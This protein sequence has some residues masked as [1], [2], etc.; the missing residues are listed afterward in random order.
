MKQVLSFVLLLSSLSACALLSTPGTGGAAPSVTGSRP[1]DGEAGVSLNVGV[2]TDL[3]LP[4]SGVDPETL[5]QDAVTLTNTATGEQVAAT[6]GSSGGFDTITLQP[7]ELLE[8]ATTYRF[9]VS[10]SVTDQNGVPFK[11]Y[12]ATFTT[13]NEVPAQLNDISFEQVALPAADGERY[14][15]L[16]L[17]ADGKLYAATVDGRIMRFAVQ[18]DGTLGTRQTITALQQAEGGPRL[19]IGFTFAPNST[20]ENL[21][22][23][24]SHTYFGFDTGDGTDGH[25]W[26]GKITRLS[27]PDLEDV[28][29]VVVGLPRS[30]KDHVTNSIAFKEGEPE[31]LYFNQGSNTAMGAPD[32]AWDYQPERLLS[33]ATLRLDLRKLSGLPLNAQTEDGG[34]Y[35]PFV[36]DAPLTLF[37]RGIRNA[38][39]LVWHSNGS[40]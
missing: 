9:D 32:A 23:Y 4:N 6:I 34:T 20:A 16:A 5:T 35:T 14:A 38:Y 18:D 21:V 40:L 12:S 2:A 8:Q 13:G 15:S 31:V 22:A 30:R 37:G 10:S 25:P 11:P 19:T 33:G 26:S 29:D 39:D 3:E 1:A 24:V 27:G 17:G 36:A 7:T 28:Q